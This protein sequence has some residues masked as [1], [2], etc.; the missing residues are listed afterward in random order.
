MSTKAS[1]YTR[2]LLKEALEPWLHD[3]RAASRAIRAGQ[4]GAAS[5][6][7][8]A[9]AQSA[10]NRPEIRRL[11]QLMAREGDL[12]KLGDVVTEI[13]ALFSESGETGHA[14]VTS[15][16]ELTA[17]ERAKLETKLRQRFGADLLF[18]YEV[19]PAILGGVRVRVGD[20]VID[21]SVASRLNAL[22]ERIVG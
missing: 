9:L 22:R 5:T 3:L 14:L 2:A 17:E 19:N 13:E 10:S 18:E 7:P 20:Q 8:A 12:G 21:G 15:A 1:I 11:L 16:I 4:S 6:D